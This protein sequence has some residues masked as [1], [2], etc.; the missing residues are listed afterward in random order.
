MIK[1][2]K[3]IEIN[4]KCL[5]LLGLLVFLINSLLPGC[6]FKLYVCFSYSWEI[7]RG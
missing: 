4:E 6:E 2:E 3:N 5:D 7:I 1:P